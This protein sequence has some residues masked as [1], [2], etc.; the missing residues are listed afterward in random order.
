M[1]AKNK[2][3]VKAIL[4]SYQCDRS[5]WVSTLQDVHVEFIYLHEDAIGDVG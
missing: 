5:L 2:Q 3:K 1:K 4:D